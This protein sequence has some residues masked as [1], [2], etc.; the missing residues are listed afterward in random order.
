VMGKCLIKS[1]APLDNITSTGKERKPRPASEWYEIYVNRKHHR[2]SQLNP[3]CMACDGTGKPKFKKS[4]TKDEPS[5]KSK[6]LESSDPKIC[7]NCN[8]SGGPAPWGASDAHREID[9]RRYMVKQF[10]VAF[11][12]K[13]R[14]L[15]DLPTRPTYAEEKLGIVHSGGTWEARL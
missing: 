9:A 8:G 3:T 5:H 15:E 10:L 6:P 13:W 11:W 7:A 12:T 1:G 14:K 2:K 4:T